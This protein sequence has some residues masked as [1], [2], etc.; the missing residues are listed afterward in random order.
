MHD[1]EVLAGRKARGA[2]LLAVGGFER[3]IELRPA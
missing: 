3:G 2:G 1:A